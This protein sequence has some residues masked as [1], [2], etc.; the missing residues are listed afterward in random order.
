LDV[1]L[2]YKSNE[3]K[4]K[5]T[6]KQMFRIA[7]GSKNQNTMKT[8][9]LTLLALALVVG[10]MTSCKKKKEA[11]AAPAENVKSFTFTTTN[12]AWDLNNDQYTAIYTL[13]DIDMDVLSKGSVTV[14]R[15]DGTG[16]VWTAI[17]VIVQNIQY[18][19]NIS[20]NTVKIITSSANSEHPVIA[21]PGVQQFRVVVFK[22]SRK[23]DPN[24]D[25]KNYDE[26]KETFHIAD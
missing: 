10:V 22:G 1:P 7:S 11:P 2:F 12:S 14:Y 6:L 3:L 26:V 8:T 21:N 24:I 15:G 16:S 20:L 23:A 4:T 18:S 17:P 13:T 5:T 25:W 9:K 19:Q